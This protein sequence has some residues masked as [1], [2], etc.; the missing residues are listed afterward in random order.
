LA[1]HSLKAFG[2]LNIA[3]RSQCIDDDVEFGWSDNQVETTAIDIEE[4]FITL[5][6][7]VFAWHGAGN[8]FAAPCGPH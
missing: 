1:E 5:I 3:D 4:R 8:Y 7:R 6:A 2:Q